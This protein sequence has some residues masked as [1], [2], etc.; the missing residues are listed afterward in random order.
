MLF[1]FL[2]F[3]PYMMRPILFEAHMETLRCQWKGITAIGLLLALNVSLNNS[4]LVEMTL[5]LNQII[6]ASIP[7]FTCVFAIAIEGEK[8]SA[9]EFLS[10]VI[11]T[12]GVMLA[13]WQSAVD[14]SLKGLLLCLSGTICSALMMTTY[15][16]ILSTKIDALRLVFYTS[17]LSWMVLLP[18]ALYN[19]EWNAFVETYAIA[20]RREA[21]T[22][23]LCTSVLALAYNIVHSFV[24]Q[25]T[26]AV[27]TTVLGEVKI[28][29]LVVLS[30]VLFE[31]SKA[32]TIKMSV[33]CVTALVGFC[34]YTHAK[35]NRHVPGAEESSSNQNEVNYGTSMFAESVTPM[36]AA[37]KEKL[38]RLTKTLSKN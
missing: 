34:L 31:E 20:S 25:H 10:L 9:M 6:R 26:S 38:P 33:G 13:M 18:T 7:V 32:F 2:C 22:A 16:K 5:S 30:Y 12:C 36:L 8:P 35:Q 3:T 11:L 27:T 4:S 28:I 24:I 14:G 19:G 29:G 21:C 1:A 23:V 15:G 17:P 37:K